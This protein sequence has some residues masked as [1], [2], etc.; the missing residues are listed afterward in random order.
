ME[1]YVLRHAIAVAHDAPG[2]TSDE[3]RALTPDG[4]EK[5]REAAIGMTRLVAGFDVILTSPLVRARQT[6]DIVA[7]VFDCE[8]SVKECQALAPGGSPPEVFA[9]IKKSRRAERVLLVGHQPDLGELVSLLVWGSDQVSVP[10]KK[11]G[12]CRVDVT[13]MPPRSLGTLEWL[14]TPKQLRLMANSQSEL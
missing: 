3:E 2:I 1:L 9:A 13:E 5:M 7:E 4:I 14:L 12:L 8:K 6:A 10:L 11:G